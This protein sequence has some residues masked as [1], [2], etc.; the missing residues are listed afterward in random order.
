MMFSWLRFWTWFGTPSR[1]PSPRENRP[2]TGERRPR[3]ADTPEAW[4][5]RLEDRDARL[6]RAAAQALGRLGPAAAGAVPGLL[7][8]AVDP[9]AAV[10]KAAAEA[11]SAVD[12]DWPGRGACGEAIPS[13]LRALDSSTADVWKTAAALLT[14]LG[15]AAVP[16][17]I[18]ELR[19]GGDTRQTMAARIV[20][21]LGPDAADAVPH[22]IKPLGSEHTHL[23]QAAVEAL[24]GIGTAAGTAVPALVPLLADWHPTVRVAAARALPKVGWPAGLAVPALAQMFADRDDEVRAAAAEGLG[25]AG[26]AAVS[27]LL[28]L[29]QV[30]E[31]RPLREKLVAMAACHEGLKGADW[32]FRQAVEEH[33]RPAA[34]REGGAKALGG[35]GPDAAAAVPALTRWLGDPNRATRQ[36]AAWAL[37]RI[38]PAAAEAV[39]PLVLA[40]GDVFGSVRM[41]AIEALPAIDPSWGTNPAVQGPIDTLLAG[42][43]RSGEDAKPAIE[44]LCLIGAWAVPALL[45][46]LSAPDRNQREGAAVVLGRIGPPAADAIG[47]LMSAL[48]DAHSWVRQAAVDAL[49]KIDPDGSLRARLTAASP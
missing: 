36:A 7:G 29:L 15:R 23:R 46:A 40:V 18:D 28:E 31:P 47:G 20:A 41:A 24:A 1:R 13:L 16:A 5:E 30:S 34:L 27:P 44:G 48:E 4:A 10:R 33:L 2:G 9:D 8:A 19:W 25:Q 26:P 35:I 32:C 3:V 17:L 11:L 12:P 39:G 49:P 22:L 6:R 21:R 43:T 38:G 37:G 42:L 14:R 45:K